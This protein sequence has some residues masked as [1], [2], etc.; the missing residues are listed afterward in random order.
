MS[1]IKIAKEVGSLPTTL[2]ANTMYAIRVGRGF[3]L[4]FTD[5]N[6]AVANSL[7]TLEV[8]FFSFNT[9][10]FLST[11]NNYDSQGAVKA[12]CLAIGKNASAGSGVGATDAFAFGE[13]AQANGKSSIAMGGRAGT[14]N[15][16]ATGD[17]AVAIGAAATAVGKSA[18]A[19]GDQSD[20]H[21]DYAFAFGAGSETLEEGGV[22]IGNNTKAGHYALGIGTAS[23]AAGEYSLAIGYFAKA[24]TNE[25]AIGKAAL[26]GADGNTSQDN[27]SIGHQ[28]LFNNSFADKSVVM[29][30]DAGLGSQRADRTILIGNKASNTANH[31][32]NTILVGYNSGYAMGYAG[33]PALPM[34]PRVHNIGIGNANSQVMMG[35]YNVSIGYFSGAGNMSNRSINIGHKS[36]TKQVIDETTDLIDVAQ[37]PGLIQAGND[38]IS[39]GYQS[40]ANGH[41]NSMAFGSNAK[42]TADNQVM[43]GDSSVAQMK[44]TNVADADLTTASTEA[45]TGKQVRALIAEIERI[46]GQ[47]VNL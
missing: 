45:V 17:G 26:K 38:N 3:D 41:N 35:D 31:T 14:G 36:G 25:L 43:L 19:F 6:G 32:T 28:A 34:Q 4:Y 13:D 7:N 22:A 2:E 5:S 16:S 21:A 23:N 44:V 40:N 12:G 8:P 46:T 11:D 20:A 27:V 18:F 9:S 30:N 47:T 24:L 33:D 37:A 39:I 29:G 42:T 10:G 1:T 15:T